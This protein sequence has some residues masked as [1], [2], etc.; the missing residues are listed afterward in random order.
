MAKQPRL[1]AEH[2]AL[3]MMI[4]MPLVFFSFLIYGFCASIKPVLFP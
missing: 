2:G 1:K 4:F 3:G